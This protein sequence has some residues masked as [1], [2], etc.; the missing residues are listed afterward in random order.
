M[1][2]SISLGEIIDRLRNVSVRTQ[3]GDVL[4]D[5]SEA[6]VRV[7]TRVGM[8][9]SV[10]QSGLDVDGERR[11]GGQRLGVWRS[12]NRSKAILGTQTLRR[13]GLSVAGATVLGI[14]F[15]ISQLESPSRRPDHSRVYTTTAG[16]SA[17]ITLG[18]GSRVILAPRSRLSVVDAGTKARLVSLDGEAYFI[19]AQSATVPFLVQ[20]GS[21]TTRV[22]GTEFLIRHSNMA[23]VRVSVANGKVYMADRAHQKRGVILSAGQIGDL[24]DSTIHVTAVDDVTPGTEWIQGQLVFH[25]MPVSTI[26]STM[27]QWYGYQ[28]RCADS[29]LPRRT[30]TMVVSMQ[31]SVEVLAVLEQVLSVNLAITGDTIMLTPHLNRPATGMPRVREYDV[32]SPNREVGR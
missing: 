14:L 3:R 12:N 2:S 16:Q 11:D 23:G 29:T 27:S 13:W 17:T 28:F 20:T 18:D 8:E 19:V 32:W 31:S 7:E 15:F 10:K 25:D 26:L 21:V 22:L 1:P 24:S 30:V 5:V 4:P 9:P 6:W